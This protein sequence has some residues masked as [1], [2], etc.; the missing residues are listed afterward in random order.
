MAVPMNPDSTLRRVVQATSGAA[1]LI[2]GGMFMM[3]FGGLAQYGRTVRWPLA[4]VI[5][6]YGVIRIWGAVRSRDSEDH[7]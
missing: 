1:F 7:N 2:L 5:V 6:T 3:G 4:G